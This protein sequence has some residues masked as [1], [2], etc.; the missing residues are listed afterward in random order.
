MEVAVMI[1]IQGS[2]KSTFAHQHLGGTHVRLSLD[3][4]KHRS[5]ERALHYACLAAGQRFV[6]DNTNPDPQARAGFIAAA[7]AAGFRVVAYFF[8]PDLDGAAARNSAREGKARVPDV[9]LRVTAGK[10]TRPTQDEG[11]DACFDVTLD[12]ATST[13]HVQEQWSCSTT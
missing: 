4:L 6:I 12:A 3:A 9:A 5:R 1:G 11:F 2:G 7:R 10:L 8:P 13:F